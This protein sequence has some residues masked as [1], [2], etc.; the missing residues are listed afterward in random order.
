[1]ETIFDI[2]NLNTMCTS[3]LLLA[4]QAV[5]FQKQLVFNCIQRLFDT[6][7]CVQQKK[8][9]FPILIITIFYL[10]YFCILVWYVYIFRAYFRI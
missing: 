4:N 10:A 8:T 3:I 5:I 7:V 9:C 1:M 2:I 6:R